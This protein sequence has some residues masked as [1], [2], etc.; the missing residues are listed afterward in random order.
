MEELQERSA[1]RKG[2][3]IDAETWIFEVWV[4]VVWE[5]PWCAT[6][7]VPLYSGPVDKS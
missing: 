7:E 6:R 2:I 5:R 1:G 4:W 3:A